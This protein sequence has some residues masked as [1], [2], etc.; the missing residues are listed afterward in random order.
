VFLR[1]ELRLLEPASERFI[2]LDDSQ[3]LAELGLHQVVFRREQA[4]LL[5]GNF[6]AGGAARPP[7]CGV[8]MAQRF[9]L[10]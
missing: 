3:L 7:H 8:L 10:T 2:H 5:L 6:V 1:L 9:A 4:F